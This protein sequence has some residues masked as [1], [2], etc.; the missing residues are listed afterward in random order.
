MDCV[1]N[2]GSRTRNADL[3]NT[4]SADRPRIV[5]DKV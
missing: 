4:S 1:G 5:K 3:S 2:G